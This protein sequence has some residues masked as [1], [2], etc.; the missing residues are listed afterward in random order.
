[1]KDSFSNQANVGQA[2]Y[3]WTRELY[4]MY[5]H[6]LRIHTPK[7]KEEN[8]AKPTAQQNPY[9]GIEPAFNDLLNIWNKIH[10]P[11]RNLS[12]DEEIIYLRGKASVIQYI[13]NKRNRFGPKLFMLSG[14]NEGTT[15]KGY[16]HWGKLYRGS[17]RERP[18]SFAAFGK[19]YEMVMTAVVALHLRWFGYWIYMDSWFTGLPLLLHGRI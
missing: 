3:G 4:T 11:S 16:L 2:L 9:F 14:S 15:Q 10:Y 12:I 17:L 13:Q 18:T 1:M 8:F 7:D 5:N 19:G 6:C